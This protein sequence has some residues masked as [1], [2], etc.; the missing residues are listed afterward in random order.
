[1]AP[2]RYQQGGDELPTASPRTG[3]KHPGGGFA[4]DGSLAEELYQGRNRVGNRARRPVR[5]KLLE[6]L[7]ITPSRR[8]GKNSATTVY[9]DIS[10]VVSSSKKQNTATTTLN[11]HAT[12]KTARYWTS[13]K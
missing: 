7:P 1:M 3:T 12:F 5:R 13:I 2:Q 11:A 9:N 10:H 4:E 8:G 6:I